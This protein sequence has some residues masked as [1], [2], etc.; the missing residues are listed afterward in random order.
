MEVE[1]DH[2]PALVLQEPADHSWLREKEEEHN[3]GLA[4]DRMP[5]IGAG[6]VKP[7]AAELHVVQLVQKCWVVQVEMA[8]T[9]LAAEQ[10]VRHTGHHSECNTL[11]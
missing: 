7:R 4:V 1:Q 8:R 9:H 6:E 11:H 10:S 3:P 2:P 5:A